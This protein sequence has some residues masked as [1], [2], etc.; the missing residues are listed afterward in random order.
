MELPSDGESDDGSASPIDVGLAK[1]AKKIAI[2]EPQDG[3]AGLDPKEKPLKVNLDLAL[4]RAKM[5]TRNYR[6]AEAQQILEKVYLPFYY[7]FSCTIFCVHVYF[8]VDEI[9]VCNFV[10][11]SVYII[12]RK[13]GELMWPW[14]RP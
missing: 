9:E 8:G 14:G 13:M 3:A 1:F 5:L 10:C 7:L 11:K 6:Y 2:F 12:G 4:Y